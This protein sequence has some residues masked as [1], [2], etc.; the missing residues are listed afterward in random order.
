MSARAL[1]ALGLAAIAAGGLTAAAFFTFTVDDAYIVLRYARHLVTAGEWAFNP[2]EP[3]MAFTSPLHAMLAAMFVAASDAHA[4]QVNKILMMLL[5]ALS[6]WLLTRRHPGGARTRALVLVLLAGSPFIWMWAVG[7]LETM[8]VACLLTAFA[9][10]HARED[11]PH[12]AGWMAAL[13]GVLFLARYDSVFFVLP[14]LGGL[15]WR[16]RRREG[17]GAVVRGMALAAALPALWLL[18]SVIYFHDIVPTSF[19]VKASRDITWFKL[20]YMGQF[21]LVTGVLPLWLMALAGI[22]RGGLGDRLASFV[23]Q[24]GP[25]LAGLAL[26]FA[27]GSAHATVHMMFGYRLLL[28]YL[29]VL[30]L[31]GIDL[32]ELVVAAEGNEASRARWTGAV[33]VFAAAMLALQIGQSV[34]VY[35]RSLGGLGITGEYR[36]MGLSAYRDVFMPVM[37][38]GCRDLAAHAATIQ[39]FNTRAPRFLTFAEG[40]IPYCLDRLYVYGHLVSFRHGINDGYP[41]D[42]RFQRSADYVYV[43]APR[44]GSVAAQL[45]FPVEQYQEISTHT[46][47]YNGADETFA[48]YF[49][50]S[51]D[52][53]ALPARVR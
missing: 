6:A 33:A 49:N 14:V 26:L 17:V 19:H 52:D 27:Y 20:A 53:E 16:Q 12:V 24:R 37:E 2:G 13:A 8:L 43:L 4:L 10:L 7:G 42:V 38:S 15:W 41:P 22:W 18:F 29:P 47:E 39:R 28:P 21:L 1:G 11:Q 46:I 23:R 32:L 30:I 34:I 9:R 5:V 35:S 51:P 45:A 25:L 44:H 50:P 40:L 36:A 31:L 3:V 48:I